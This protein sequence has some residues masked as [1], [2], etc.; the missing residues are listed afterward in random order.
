MHDNNQ[1][2]NRAGLIKEFY[3][4]IL[5]L[6]IEL[7]VLSCLSKPALALPA[8]KSDISWYN[9]TKNPYYPSDQCVWYAWGRASEIMGKPLSSGS[10]GNGG[11]FWNN[12]SSNYS[13]GQSP[14]EGAIACGGGNT[15]YGHVA[16][17]ESVNSNGTITF[18]EVWGSKHDGVV[19]TVTYAN[20]PT[21]A[22]ESGDGSNFQGYI[23]IPTVNDDVPPVI[24]NVQISDV[25][26][27][28][29]TVTCTVTDNVGIGRVQAAVWSASTTPWSDWRTGASSRFSQNGNTFTYRVKASDHNN[30][31]GDYGLH[32]YAWD[33]SGNEASVAAPKAT[34]PEPIPAPDG[35]L[36][37]AQGGLGTVTLKGWAY[38]PNDPSKT[39][40][41]DMYIGGNPGDANAEKHRV[42][43]DQPRE[44]VNSA[45]GIEG[46]HGF[47]VTIP[48]AKSGNQTINMYVLGLTS[49]NN[50]L[51]ASKDVSIAQDTEKPVISDVKVISV[52]KS[53][54]TISCKVTDNV[55]VDRVQ[56]PTW[57]S[58]NGQDDL[59][60]NW[61]TNEAVRG[62]Q[63][64]NTWTFRVKASEHNNELGE[65]ATDI[66][67]YD[68]AGNYAKYAT[69][70]ANLADTIDISEAAYGGIAD[71]RETG[72]PIEPRVS[73][74]YDNAY[75]EEGTDYTLSYVNNTEIGEATVT[76]KGIG[77]FSGTRSETFSIVGGRDISKSFPYHLRIG[78]S[79]INAGGV[80][81]TY[82]GTAKE[83]GF[84]SPGKP[85]VEETVATP[86]MT[87]EAS[88]RLG[89]DFTATYKNN[90]N[91]G[92]AVCTVTGISKRLYGTRDITFEIVPASISTASVAAIADQTHT[93]MALKPKP[94]LTFNGT[95]LKEG[96]DYTLSYE[97]NIEVGQA[98]VTV[99]GRGNFTG[100]TS[101][102]FNIV[103]D[104]QG[105][106]PTPEPESLANATVSSIPDQTFNGSACTP[107]P[108]VQLGSKTLVEGTDYE[109]F[110]RNN[111]KVGTASVVVIGCGT[112]TGTKTASFKIVAPKPIS[113]SKAVV[114]GVVNKTYTGKA[115][116]QKPV[117]KVNGKTLKS[118]TDYELFYR[119]NINVGTA[120]VAI[121]GKGAYTG[122]ISKSFKI[123]KAK[124]GMAA[125]GKT[126]TLKASKVAAATQTIT[127]AKVFTLKNANGK[128]TFKKVSGNN[129][130]AISSA[131]K[132]TVKKG[133]KKGTYK[134]KVKVTAAGDKNH[135][136]SS[137]VV[138]IKVVIK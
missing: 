36:D 84:F 34:L 76:I 116:T 71:H 121:L 20:G 25:S 10:L 56:F 45:R 106:D 7:F 134:V 105:S 114:S 19:H 130:I 67:A 58:Y 72:S 80:D 14:R 29:Y 73:L 99:A 37:V 64:G 9:T 119:N 41:V 124:N 107:S 90:V 6:L 125:A 135:L 132:V 61:Q 38:D 4:I 18:S 3:L 47:D 54:Y 78:S 81:S 48:V 28:G 68:K 46:D 13:R 104:Q 82:D 62:S 89:V 123:V 131:G 108:K 109:L 22:S 24:S 98:M 40:A 63:N 88:D 137:K 16:I 126:I 83:P 49:G 136:S 77:K 93:G 55:H 87:I 35:R 122:S 111:T 86:K 66:Y 101:T 97:D 43:A 70:A 118:G 92:T 91:V 21:W 1:V 33:T 60:P 42:L 112:Y 94:V 65:Y 53:G 75:L 57:T 12:V 5:C 27:S 11:D 129:K 26:S 138:T 100:T 117:V 120:S 44:D 50:K 31:Y 115:Q 95:T 85:S 110:Y 52:S 30:D 23:Y 128:V 8:I 69:V 113:I 51:V 17:V 15:Q 39:V 103:A 127:K 133:L 2:G 102:S 74:V 32:V 79:W 59:A 96:T